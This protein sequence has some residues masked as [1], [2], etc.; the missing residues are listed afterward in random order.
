MDAKTLLKK[1]WF[2]LVVGLLLIVFVVFWGIDTSKNEKEK[3]LSTI[4]TR[5]EDGK[6]IL[7]SVDGENGLNA[8]DFYETIDENSRNGIV[9]SQLFET[10]ADK[11]IKT[12]EEIKTMATNQASY[13]LTNSTEEDIEQLMRSNGLM[14][15]GNLTTYFEYRFKEQEL[16]KEYMTNHYEDVVKP[17]VEEN[18][19]KGV[20][21][22]LIKVADVE[23]TTDDQ[24]NTIHVAY[25]TEEE[26]KKLNDVLEALKTRDFADVALEYSDDSSAQNGGL[27]GFQKD[28]DLDQYVEEFKNC[29]RELEYDTQ[30][31]VI[32]SQYGYH[33]ILVEECK[34]ENYDKAIQTLYDIVNADNSKEYFNM[35]IEYADKFNVEIV[36]ESLKE[37]LD[38][39][40]ASEEDSTEETTSED[41]TETEGE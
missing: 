24:G 39:H 38:E 30:S 35:I 16:I 5:V 17:Y 31:E 13:Y 37:L 23:E 21:H 20:S 19:I 9:L 28:S 11:E 25:P 22:I 26:E 40:R 41:T 12:T 8:D 1:Y 36:D 7:F 4:Q 32:T 10:L 14:K 15:Y 33:I 18:K 27:L 34:P 3:E 29:T 6:Y 2:V